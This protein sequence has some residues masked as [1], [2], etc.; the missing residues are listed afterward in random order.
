[1]KPDL[2]KEGSKEL[3]L[4]Y[5]MSQ[6]VVEQH[7]WFFNGA[8]I[9]NSSHYSVDGSSLVITGLNRRDTGQYTVQLTNPFS[10]VT[11]HMNVTVLCK[12]NSSD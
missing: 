7:T 3:T 12:I 2:A 9:K 8:E 11:A 10:N 5:S 6:G 1:M 4:Q